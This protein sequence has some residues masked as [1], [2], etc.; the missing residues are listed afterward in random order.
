MPFQLLRDDETQ[1]EF[2]AFVPDDIDRSV[3][4][5]IIVFL[6]GSGERGFDRGLPLKGNAH[7]FECLQLPAVVIFP[8]CDY[9][10]RA[11]YG[12]MEEQ[13]FRCVDI[14][15]REFRADAE[16]IF[17]TG[18][19]MGGSS[20]LWVAAKHAKR[21]A[22]IA[23]IAPGITWMGEEPP[24]HLP[25]EDEELFNSMFVVGNRT[26]K[27]AE[28]IKDIPIWFLQGTED[29]PCPIEETRMLVDE[30]RKLG[31]KP[32]FTEYAGIDHESLTLA[33]EQ[34]GLFE[35]LLSHRGN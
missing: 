32:L 23:C 25:S 4:F 22:S 13:V 29:E 17:L 6:H 14:A 21:I 20:T 35:W 5:P 9:E 34:N 12:A 15:A 33:L 16:R 2:A 3:N 27:I 31:A 24:P 19:S 1:F 11:F 10:H 8:Q 7:V 26:P 28:Q 30:L 18:Y